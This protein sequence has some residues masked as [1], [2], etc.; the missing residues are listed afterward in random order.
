[1]PNAFTLSGNTFISCCVDQ[2]ASGSKDLTFQLI[3]YRI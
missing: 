3:G 1:L 2:I